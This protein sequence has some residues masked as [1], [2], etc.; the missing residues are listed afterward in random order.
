M[1]LMGPEDRV[2]RFGV[3]ELN[4]PAGE[5][6]KNGFRLKLAEQPFRILMHLA[7]RPGEIV[8]REELRDL[9]WGQDTFV[10]FEHG[11]N[12][13]INKI[14]E[15]LG[16]SAS[17]PR[18]IETVPRRG[19]R[20][21]GEV[22]H[23]PVRQPDGDPAGT[24]EDLEKVK[25][26]PQERPA[27]T[28]EGNRNPWWWVGAAAILALGVAGG[29]WW[30]RSQS[31]LPTPQL[32]MR[33]L[34]ADAGLTTHPVLSGDG[35]LVAYA[36]DRATLKNLDIWVHPLTEG[37]RPIRLTTHE[38]DDQFPDFSPDGGMIAFHS[39][40]E[41][42]GIYL[43]PVPGG[44]E[45]L[46]VRGGRLPRFSPDGK[47]ITY[48]TGCDWL[49]PS[50]IYTIPVSGGTAKQVAADVAWASRPVFSADGR[51][52][53]FEGAPAA[54]DPASHDLWVG[55]RDGGSSVKTGAYSIL[56]EQRIRASLS[57]WQNDL[58]GGR[59]LFALESGIWELD[60]AQPSW[61]ARGPARLLTSGNTPRYVR[62]GS[63]SRMV[64]VNTQFSSHLWKLKVDHNK[65]KALG[66]M[67]PLP[68]AGGRQQQPSVS[69]DGRL[70]AY[71]QSEP[72]GNALRVR[73]LGTAKETTLVSSVARPKVSPDG[74]RVAYGVFPNSIYLIPPS[75]GEA[76]LLVRPQGT[77]SSQ[78]YG[79]TPDGKRIVYWTGKPIR[80]ALLDPETRRSTD[81]VAHPT[82]D[83]HGAELS[84]DQR[85]VAFNTP[86]GK[87]KPLW[88]ASYRE[89]KAAEEKDW[90]LVSED[91]DERPW[92]S[93]DGNLLYAVGRRDG[94]SCIWAFRL[95]PVTRRPTGEP[96]AV[97]HVHGARVKVTSRGRAYFGPAILP[98]GLV[99]SLDDES[100][101]V[102]IA[103]PK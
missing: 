87:L 21:I 47:S 35:K 12:A 102:W 64:F 100:G 53:L 27:P 33:P 45:R 1:T 57:S 22:G 88:I 92:W 103:E 56:A 42:G 37:G 16:D 39:E 55:P 44:E 95:D 77:F 81:L 38:A 60:L 7:E 80:F 3:F 20:F 19:Y 82:Y 54:N 65:G 40:R 68:H 91:L 46:L 48:C 26:R 15:T 51:H 90:I 10:D 50:K 9:L 89:G 83:I 14:R 70:L 13:A 34:T 72:A 24:P 28:S 84:P 78:I 58:L 23:P 6:R 71:S 74:S 66:E 49:I 85:W 69:A 4:A 76:S 32:A 62:A 67:E 79:W 59:I 18:Y 36:S 2:V 52:I 8:T 63:G 98:D 30:E 5:L 96:F 86:T 41:G 43:V 101:N 29:A 25:G 73:D 94:V 17:T 75:G 31:T 99:F 97:Q 93:P 11:L 61:Q